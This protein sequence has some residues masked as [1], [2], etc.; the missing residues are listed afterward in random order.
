MPSKILEKLIVEF[1]PL[2]LLKKYNQENFI[3]NIDIKL[4]I[5]MRIYYFIFDLINRKHK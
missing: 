2:D 4:K 1:V 5:K 3:S